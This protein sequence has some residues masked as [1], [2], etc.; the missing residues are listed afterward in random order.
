MKNNLTKDIN[1]YHDN[2][3]KIY[4]S[5]KNPNFILETI[6]CKSI[7]NY[8]FYET[9]KINE[10]IQQL[11]NLD[12]HLSNNLNLIDR[13]FD[14]SKN[15]KNGSEYHYFYSTDG[16]DHNYNYNNNFINKAFNLYKQLDL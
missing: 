14:K 16:N 11:K 7:Y 9:T 12:T 10:K 6:H 1:W 5:I 2:I 4:K 3:D 15:V 8:L 13:Q